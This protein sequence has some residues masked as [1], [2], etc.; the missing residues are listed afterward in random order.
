MP[1]ISPKE[2]KLL[3]TLSKEYRIVFPGYLTPEDWPDCH[4]EKLEAVAALGSKQYSSYAA[5]PGAT[6]DAPWKAGVKDQADKLVEAA[7]RARH[8]NESTWRFSCEPLILSRLSA[9][10]VWYVPAGM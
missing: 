7:K 1:T 3:E 8:R 9:E 2:L 6:D 10:V 5:E 4:R